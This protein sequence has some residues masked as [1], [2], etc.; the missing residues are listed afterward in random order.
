MMNVALASMSEML[1]E[2]PWPMVIGLLGVSSVLR[3]V[4]KRQAQKKLVAVSWVALVLGLGVYAASALV[5]TAREAMI[6]G[7]EAF[8]SATSPAD[9]AVL[10]GLLASNAVLLGP[11]GSVWDDLSP[12]FIADELKENDVQDNAVRSVDA[13]SDRP[14]LGVSTLDL[15]SKVRGYPTPTTWQFDWQKQSDGQWRITSI[16]WLTIRN[17]EPTRN[18]Y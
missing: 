10:G 3:V 17:G 5:N 13:S 12:G 15:A 11:D 6:A 8:V 1:F 18:I 16:R 4:G 14:G 7:T 2:N 9:Q